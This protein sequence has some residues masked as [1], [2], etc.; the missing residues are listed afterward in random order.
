MLPP[1]ILPLT[2]AIH[3]HTQLSIHSFDLS[4]CRP[5]DALLVGGAPR[6]TTPRVIISLLVI[7]SAGPQSLPS[8]QQSPP[9]PFP[10]PV[11]SFA[12][13]A[14]PSPSSSLAEAGGRQ[15]TLR[16]HE[17]LPR[18]G[19]NAGDWHL[20]APQPALSGRVP[21]TT[22]LYA[23]RS[24]QCS[25]SQADV[26]RLCL[27]RLAAIHCGKIRLADPRRRSRV[28]R[29][30]AVVEGRASKPPSTRDTWVPALRRPWYVRDRA[31]SCSV[32]PF[33]A[34]SC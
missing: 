33:F 10:P 31:S 18:G 3:T 7:G 21:A 34:M 8:R 30:P 2:S 23:A 6:Y 25:I 20:P 5:P 26:R 4:S 32:P 28:P 12:F 15:A 1:L 19:G 16:Q 14:P 17:G 29:E 24:P 27:A 11:L 9:E 22:L 13:S